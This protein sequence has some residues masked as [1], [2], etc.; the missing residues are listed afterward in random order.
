M[1]LE[2]ATVPMD[3]FPLRWRFTDPGYD[4]LPA[5]HLAQLK[6]LAP[7]DAR[8]LWDTILQTGL[9][10]AVPFADGFFRHFIGTPVG[11]SHGDKD[12]GRRVRKWLYR[13]GIPFRQRVWLCYEPETA[14][15]TTWKVLLKYWT[16]LYY[17]ISDD[18]T[19]VDE[20][21][22]WA[23]LFHHEEEV[24]FGSNFP[25]MAGVQK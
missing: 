2:F 8:R 21:L 10:R 14:I 3:Q 11:D 18:L 16:A 1:S 24:Y 9:H 25:T 15:E 7:E 5:V 6:P 22:N 13:C 4:V 12:E 20:S 19:V 17:P 23:V